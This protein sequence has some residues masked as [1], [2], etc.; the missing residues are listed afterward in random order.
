MTK[1]P[2]DGLIETGLRV[3]TWNIW[4]RHGAWQERAPAIAATL[5]ALDA[6]II[7]LQEVWSDASSNYAAILAADLGYHHVYGT[8]MEQK[9]LLLGD[10]ILSRWPIV[11]HQMTRLYDQT[12]IEENRIA[13]FADIDGPRGRLPVFCTHLSWK[14]QHS[15]IR[16]R[17][18]ADIARF[19]Q[20]NHTCKYPPVVCGDF[21]ADPQSTE[22][23]IMTGQTTCP[24]EGMVF[25]DA[26][27]FAGA[28]GPGYTWD[29]AN[30]F[31]AEV[32]EPSRRID[33]IFAG[34]PG[35]RGAGHIVECRITGNKPVK[36]VWPS[37]HYG[38]L[39]ELRY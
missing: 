24:V 31:A 32:L 18:V 20:K 22:I 17:Q 27:A 13:I 12:G 4:W 33:Y 30:P 5:S 10:A 25:H 23:R 16:Q 39:A 26:W 21:N 3:L 1:Q 28:D 29:N 14:Q 37:D 7:A 34:W 6:D 9:G 15:H 38:L 2:Q 36:G 35:P 19:V 8:G 11:R